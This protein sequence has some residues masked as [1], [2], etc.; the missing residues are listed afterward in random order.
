VSLRAVV[1][2]MGGILWDGRERGEVFRVLHAIAGSGYRQ[3]LLTN[4]ASAFLGP[5]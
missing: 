4:D 2:D 5:G 1:W 3:G